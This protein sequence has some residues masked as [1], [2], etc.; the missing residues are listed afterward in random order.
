MDNGEKEYFVFDVTKISFLSHNE[1]EGAH[2]NTTIHFGINQY[3]FRGRNN[4]NLYDEIRN[5]MH[6][7]ET[8]N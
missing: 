7:L 4:K 8:T 6:Q 3:N 5:I 1:S 2:G